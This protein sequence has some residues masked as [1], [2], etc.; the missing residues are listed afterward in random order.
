MTIKNSSI[1]NNT[2]HHYKT[3]LGDVFFFDHYFIAEF[4]EGLDIDYSSFEEIH[5]LIKKHYGNSPFA[6]I[7]NRINSYS[8]VLP[9]AA[10]FNTTFPNCKAY[11]IIA[12]SAITEK[13]YQIE[14]HF[15]H[16]NRQI[17]SNIH[18]AIIWVESSLHPKK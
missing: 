2:H 8:I 6:F 11:A 5:G 17:F 14:N 3:N 18:E 12:Y 9:D 13:I 1:L 15:F 4:K 7:A 16:F 10:R